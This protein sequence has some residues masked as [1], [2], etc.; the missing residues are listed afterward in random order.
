MRQ[1]GNLIGVSKMNVNEG[2]VEGVGACP[3]C[4]G[5][6]VGRLG[7]GQY[8]CRECYIEFE[9]TDRGWHLFQIGDEG[10]LVFW[11]EVAR[12]GTAGQGGGIH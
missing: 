9:T 11:K 2:P 12:P 3:A 7:L 5:R 8:Y 4:C 1:R 10:D 6:G